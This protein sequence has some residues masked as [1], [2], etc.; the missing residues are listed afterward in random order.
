LD[1]ATL[2][3]GVADFCGLLGELREVGENN[4]S[5]EAVFTGSRCKGPGVGF[6][7]SGGGVSKIVGNELLG[8][9]TANKTL[10]NFSVLLDGNSVQ[11]VAQGFKVRLEAEL[12]RRLGP[13][14][15]VG[16]I[17]RRGNSFV[18]GGEN[19]GVSP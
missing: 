6:K 5:A 17:F 4:P 11:G 16:N 13:D 19:N 3:P 10:S 9:I 7:G 8:R 12:A 2:D 1:F 18:L 14:L 15:G